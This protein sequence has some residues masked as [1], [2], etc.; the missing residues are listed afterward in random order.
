MVDA[1]TRITTVKG[2]VQ[3]AQAGSECLVVIYGASLGRKYDLVEDVVTIGRDPE[4]TIVLDV[5]SVSRRHAKVETFSG[6][7]YV[8]DLNSTNGT[9]LNDR[10]AVREKL[11]NGDLMK[12]GDTIFKFLAGS[13]IESAYHE[14]IY[15]M[16]WSGSSAGR[17]ATAAPSPASCSTSTTSSRSTTSTAT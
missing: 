9:Y 2:I 6:N 14:E 1:K 16:T 3:A 15:T 12:V 4:N 17:A 11:K 5:D 7:K 8:V 13:N 10:L